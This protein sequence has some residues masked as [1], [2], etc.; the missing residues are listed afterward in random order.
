MRFMLIGTKCLN[1]L[2]DS[3]GKAIIQNHITKNLNILI[4]HR[5]NWIQVLVVVIKFTKLKKIVSIHLLTTEMLC[6]S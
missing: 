2:C 6:V 3:Y 5:R 4:K 1:T